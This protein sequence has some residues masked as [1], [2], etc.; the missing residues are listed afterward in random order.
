[1]ACCVFAWNNKDFD[2]WTQIRS[3]NF[4][5]LKNRC[6][7]RFGPLGKNA[8]NIQVQ[9]TPNN[10]QLLC[11]PNLENTLKSFYVPFNSFH[12]PLI[13]SNVK[14]V[15]TVVE[16]IIVATETIAPNLSIARP[17]QTCSDTGSQNRSFNLEIRDSRCRYELPK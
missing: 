12:F 8:N 11:P 10:E 13:L 1:M 17:L 15:V 7:K 5:H 6:M 16:F 2:V 4:T 14:G 9:A 3:I